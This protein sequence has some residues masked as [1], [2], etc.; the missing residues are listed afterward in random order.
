MFTAPDTDAVALLRSWI[1]QP[2]FPLLVVPDN[3]TAGNTAVQQARF[4]AYGSDV[5][6]TYMTSNNSS[7]FVPLQVGPQESASSVPL[8]AGN[9]ATAGS[10]NAGTKWAELLQEPEV[11][12]NITGPVI[13]KAATRFYR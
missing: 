7:W 6:D 9:L 11:M 10:G 13:N 2:G 1:T 12:L 8:R 3:N 5:N 4:Y